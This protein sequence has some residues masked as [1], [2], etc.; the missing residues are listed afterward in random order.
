MVRIHIT[1]EKMIS[2]TLTCLLSSKKKDEKAVVLC[3]RN[4]VTGRNGGV[5]WS[6]SGM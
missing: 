5:K 4:P 2:Y 1:R 6:D 3:H